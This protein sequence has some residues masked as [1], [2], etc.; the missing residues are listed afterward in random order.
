MVSNEAKVILA[1]VL[2]DYDIRLAE[3]RSERPDI[4]CLGFEILCDSKASIEVRRH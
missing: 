4:S 2:L 1:R 3:A